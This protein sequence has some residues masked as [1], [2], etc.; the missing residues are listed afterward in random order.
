MKTQTSK[1]VLLNLP[2][3]KPLAA[4]S[5][6]APSWTLDEAPVSDSPVIGCNYGS[7]QTSLHT[8]VRRLVVRS[9]ISLC[10]IV[11]NPLLGQELECMFHGKLGT[12]AT[13]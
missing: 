3:Q 12:T 4:M 1:Q 9:L 7:V 5:R 2:P 8:S 13:C 6:R 11:G 10:L